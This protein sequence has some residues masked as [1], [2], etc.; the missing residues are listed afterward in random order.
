M[1]WIGPNLQVLG[2]VVQ[3][4]IPAN[5]GIHFDSN[6]A[7]SNARWI[8]ACAGMTAE[9]KNQRWPKPEIL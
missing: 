2:E 7:F 5:A 9:A 8:P 4:V 1:T 6:G 3:V